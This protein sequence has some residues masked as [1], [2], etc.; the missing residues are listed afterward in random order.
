MCRYS[1]GGHRGTVGAVPRARTGTTVHSVVGAPYGAA[2]S[3][4]PGRTGPFW[5]AI[6]GRAPMPPVASL[7]G[8]QLEEVDP[9]TG[10]ITVSASQ[11]SHRACG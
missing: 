11:H 5:D 1:P 10:T 3:D 2:M 7:L 9:D 8:W 6:A 4:T